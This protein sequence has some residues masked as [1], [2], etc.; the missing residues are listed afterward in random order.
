ML[1][2]RAFSNH[3]AFDK[4]FNCKRCAR[5]VCK[6]CSSL[7]RLISSDAKKEE[8]VCDLCETV[9]SNY[10]LISELDL[11]YDLACDRIDLM[12]HFYT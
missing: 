7:K 2:L 10:S 5:T 6:D 1:C 8:R 9:M 12:D 11:K 4:D 3:L